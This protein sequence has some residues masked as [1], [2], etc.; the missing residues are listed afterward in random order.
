MVFNEGSMSEEAKNE[1]EKM[2]SEK[3]DILS[4]EEMIEDLYNLKY[5]KGEDYKNEVYKIITNY[6]KLNFDE[7]K[8]LMDN[9]HKTFELNHEKFKFVKLLLDNSIFPIVS[10]DFVNTIKNDT[11]RKD[12]S[13]LLK[14][15]ILKQ[16]ESYKKGSEV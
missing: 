1:A 5:L 15:A 6:Q 10:E 11:T 8:E 16:R 7:K 3:K 12:T 9:L 4:G 2:K 14:R 13:E